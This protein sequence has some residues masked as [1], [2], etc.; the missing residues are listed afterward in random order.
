MRDYP[1][2]WQGYIL[3]Q[4]GAFAGKNRAKCL[5][6]LEVRL[7]IL[8]R[9]QR[10]VESGFGEETLGR[11][12]VCVISL[13]FVIRISYEVALRWICTKLIQIPKV[14]REYCLR[15]PDITFKCA[16]LQAGVWVEMIARWG[17]DH[18]NKHLVEKQYSNLGF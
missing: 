1:L 4:Q 11:N 18:D 12:A 5:M 9:R 8:T 13:V 3:C 10:L 6:C 17:T 2:Y 7:S 16:F 15:T 14:I